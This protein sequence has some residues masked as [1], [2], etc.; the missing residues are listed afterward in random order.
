L[1]LRALGRAIRL[2][3]ALAERRPKRQ[4]TEPHDEE[5]EDNLAEHGD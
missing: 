3:F 1:R 2:A 4:E 5:H